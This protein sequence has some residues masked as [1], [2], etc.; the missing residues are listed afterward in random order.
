METWGPILLF[1]FVLLVLFIVHENDVSTRKMVGDVTSG[2]FISCRDF[3]KNWIAAEN[4]ET[5]SGLKYRD[6]PGCY[7]IT[8]F[9]HPVTDGNY[10]N[11]ENIYIG[12]S[13]NICQRVHNHF[14]GKGNGDVYAD[15]RNG[16]SV[17]VRLLRCDRKQ[18][19]DLERKLIKA[20]NATS[21]YNSTEGGGTRRT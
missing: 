4:G 17:Y 5:G 8:I 18:M 15:V 13:L 9:N 20:F 3:E 19:N 7:V 1:L 16:K 2:H 12:Q 21:S 10:R 6:G 11:Y 14:N